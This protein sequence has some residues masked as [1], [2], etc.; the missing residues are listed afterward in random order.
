MQKNSS[1]EGGDTTSSTN[2]ASLWLRLGLG[3]AM[4]PHG[5]EKLTHF[6][7]LKNSFM[8]FLG[9]SDPV[10]L[11][12]AIGAELFCS[13]LLAIGLLTRLV[14]IPLIITAF[15]IVFV[16]HRGD[17]VGEGAAGFLLLVG[18]ITS[19]LLGAG[20]Y[21]VDAVISKKTDHRFSF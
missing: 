14:L 2:I 6:A 20:K 9:L 13:I 15:V 11:A 18:Y 10:S 1:A 19:L 12:L 21:S 3:V 7:E 8:S 17:I 16:A 5:Y 4:L